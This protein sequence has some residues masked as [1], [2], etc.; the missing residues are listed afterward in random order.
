MKSVVVDFLFGAGIKR[1]MF[2]TIKVHSPS[3]FSLASHRRRIK[4]S[5]TDYQSVIDDATELSHLKLNLIVL[6]DPP[7][8]YKSPVFE[9][10]HTL[11][12]LNPAGCTRSTKRGY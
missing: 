1:A 3:S 12:E 10:L 2:S 4:S 7:S 5:W 6:G 9:H 11:S 8:E